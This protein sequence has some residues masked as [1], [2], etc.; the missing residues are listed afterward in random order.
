V[1]G[2][3]ETAKFDVYANKKQQKLE[4][5]VRM[6]VLLNGAAGGLGAEE[7]VAFSTSS[8]SSSSKSNAASALPNPHGGVTSAKVKSTSSSRNGMDS[9]SSGAGKAEASGQGAAIIVTAKFDPYSGR[10]RKVQ[11]EGVLD[12]YLAGLAAAS[13][14][15][16][17]EQGLIDSQE[18]QVKPMIKLASS[19]SSSVSDTVTTTITS[20]SSSIGSNVAASSSRGI[21]TVLPGDAEAVA[22]AAASGS[23]P[24]TAGGSRIGGELQS[25][26]I[27]TQK[28]KGAGGKRLQQQH[29]AEKDPLCGAL[30]PGDA[31]PVP[32]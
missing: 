10:R 22:A 12:D 19:S 9:S 4:A 16:A 11:G 2:A 30:L 24:S 15:L 8:S 31:L 7:P 32:T 26:K 5:D 18:T 17:V 13:T 14:A 25:Q 6:D 23:A 20:S 27:A 29:L 28:A 3:V 21:T 1:V